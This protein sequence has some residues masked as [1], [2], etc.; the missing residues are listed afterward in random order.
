MKIVS[1]ILTYEYQ[2]KE[3]RR[4]HR[5]EMEKQGYKILEELVSLDF[6]GHEHILCKYIINRK[7]YKGNSIIKGSIK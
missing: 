6:T 2:T 5:E 3:E 7:G 4:Q 1:E